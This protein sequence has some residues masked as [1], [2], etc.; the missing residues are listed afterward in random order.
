[1][2]KEFGNFL[3]PVSLQL[4]DSSV[5]FVYNNTT[6]AI[7]ALLQISQDLVETKLGGN[8]LNSREAFSTI[9]LLTADV[10]KGWGTSNLRS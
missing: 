8:S 6:V 2:I 7:E 3:S 9:P 1:M 4:D 5:F 10:N